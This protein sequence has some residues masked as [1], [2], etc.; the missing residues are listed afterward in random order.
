[1][2]KHKKCQEQELSKKTEPAFCA[3][4]GSRSEVALIVE[5]TVTVN[6]Y[7]KYIIILL[8]RSTVNKIIDKNEKI[9]KK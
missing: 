6:Y 2:S 8:L 9:D 1:M 3:F 5:F 4:R 7:K